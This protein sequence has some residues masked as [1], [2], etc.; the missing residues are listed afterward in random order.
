MVVMVVVGV[1][2]HMGVVLLTV[3]MVCDREEWSFMMVVEVTRW[4]PP[5]PS[6][7]IT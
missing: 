6:N 1:V 2:C 3:K 7:D 4:P 5:L